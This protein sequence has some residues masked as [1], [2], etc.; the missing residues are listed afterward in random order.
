MRIIRMALLIWVVSAGA[1][2][3]E[4]ERRLSAHLRVGV[5]D[6][7]MLAPRAKQMAA[8]MFATIGISLDWKD[9]PHG[10]EPSPPIVIDLVAD[11]PLD[12]MPGVLAYSVLD[13]SG[14]IIVFLDRIEKVAYPAIVL[15]H[16]IVHEITHV[17][18]AVNRH[19]STGIMQARWRRHDLCDMR[20][21]A[22]PFAPED[23]D[24]IYQGLS[25]RRR[26]AKPSESVAMKA[27]Q[28][29]L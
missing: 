2:G 27:C 3:S 17:V 18:Q 29:C 11:T 13:G 9:C 24:L 16:V 26:F 6:Q 10:S 25:Q 8:G 5:S 1:H 20:L 21:K 14:H 4:A 28:T 22:L 23:V 12:F 19:S 7:L 15:A